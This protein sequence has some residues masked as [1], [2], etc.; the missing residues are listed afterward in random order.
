MPQ[1]PAE[2][3]PGLLLGS[4]TAASDVD[5]LSAHSVTHVLNTTVEIPNFHEKRPG[6]PKYLN[7]GLQDTKDDDIAAEFERCRDFINS[8]RDSGGVVLVHCQAGI[9]SSATIVTSCVAAGGMQAHEGAGRYQQVSH[10]SHLV[11]HGREKNVAAGGVQA[12]EG[13]E[14]ERRPK[15]EV[16]RGSWEVR[17]LA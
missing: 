6:A 10:H 1:D 16:L 14:I 17:R 5:V 11:P 4:K 12:H 13:A 7:L 2:I 9:S 8:A 15:R 3:L